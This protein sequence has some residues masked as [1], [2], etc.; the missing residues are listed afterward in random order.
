MD[1]KRGNFTMVN[2][3]LKRFEIIKN[4]IAIEDEESV[5]LQV[6]KI[7]KMSYDMDVTYILELILESKYEQVIELI[8]SYIQKQSGLVVYEEKELQGLRLELKV[9][10]KKLQDI[11]QEKNEYI[12]VVHDFTTRYNLELAETIQEILYLKKEKLQRESGSE[13]IEFHFAHQEYENFRS[14]HEEEL[15]SQPFQLDEDEL[16]DLKKFYKLACK[17]CHPD[18]VEAD[19][20]TRASEIFLQLSE[21]YAKKDLLQV[22]EILHMLRNGNGFIVASDSINDIEILKE[23]I[24]ELRETIQEELHEIATI[25]NE[26]NF[27]IISNV[28]EWDRYFNLLKI[29]LEEELEELKVLLYDFSSFENRAFSYDEEWLENLYKWADKYEISDTVL[30]REKEKLLVLSRLDLSSCNLL[31]LTK[32]IGNLTH[33]QE[34]NLFKNFIIKLPKEIESLTNLKVLN[35]AENQLEELPPEIGKLIHLERLILDENQLESLPSE[36]GDLPNLVQLRLFRNQLKQLPKEIAHLVH[37]QELNV[38]GNHLN[39]LPVEIGNLTSLR[40]LN[41]MGNELVE[42][43]ETLCKLVHLEELNLG[44]NQLVRLPKGIINLVHLKDLD[45][46]LNPNLALSKEQKSW[47]NSFSEDWL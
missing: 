5:Q 34:L 9:L 42:L 38:A 32:E 6:H 4:S 33:L 35:L 39:L 47:Q 45:I 1:A 16:K 15:K 40:V 44:G 11:S 26:E 21:A 14:E 13:S 36:I 12:N 29:E 20:K 10:E 25:K 18:V 17:L 3:L 43:P 2:E 19:V 31:H 8:E 37:L 24:E 30:P 41:L 46:F 27:E 22:M 7:V 28:E 23:K